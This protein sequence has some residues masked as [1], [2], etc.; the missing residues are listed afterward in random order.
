MPKKEYQQLSTTV[1]LKFEKILKK[2][3]YQTDIS[4]SKMVERYQEAYVREQERKKLVRKFHNNRSCPLCQEA[5]I[6]TRDKH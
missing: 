3:I 2:H 5:I 6:E 4:R 1:S